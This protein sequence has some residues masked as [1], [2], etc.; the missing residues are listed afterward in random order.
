MD[1]SHIEQLAE[2]ASRRRLRYLYPFI[3]YLKAEGTFSDSYDEADEFTATFRQ[4]NRET[5]LWPG[6]G[7]HW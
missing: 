3:S 1:A 2:D 7:F 6:W 5:R 4:F